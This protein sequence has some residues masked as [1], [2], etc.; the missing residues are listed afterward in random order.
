MAIG[1]T[2]TQARTQPLGRLNIDP[3]LALAID[4][5]LTDL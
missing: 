4:S 1:E 5:L 3:M 2:Q